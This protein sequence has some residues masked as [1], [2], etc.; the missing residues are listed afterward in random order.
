MLSD[1]KVS[2]GVPFHPKMSLYYACF[3]FS[4]ADFVGIFLVILFM[5]FL[6][7]FFLIKKA[8]KGYTKGAEKETYEFNGLHQTYSGFPDIYFCLFFI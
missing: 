4:S 7:S 3:G 8:E 5:S 2:L 1:P 6:N